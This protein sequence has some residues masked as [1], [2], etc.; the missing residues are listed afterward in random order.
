MED[1]IFES[2]LAR[3][4]EV[5][6]SVLPKDLA[7]ALDISEQ[8][9][10]K[11]LNNKKI[12]KTWFY[13]IS[14]KYGVKQSWLATGLEPKAETGNLE[15]KIRN[16][17]MRVRELEGEKEQL[18]RHSKLLAEENKFVWEVRLSRDKD[19]EHYQK[20]IDG[21]LQQLQTLTLKGEPAISDA[22][23]SAPYAPSISLI[24]DE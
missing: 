8:A 11:A 16:L 13:R 10:Y 9:V 4:G 19:V 23:A 12:P 20:T 24:S 14:S 5:V 6:G 7:D 22:P 1:I 3:L 17:E 18:E 2:I 21:L 15:E